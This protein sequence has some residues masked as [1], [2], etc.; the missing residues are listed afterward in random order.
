MSLVRTT[1]MPAEPAAT[2]DGTLRVWNNDKDGVEAG[3]PIP[4]A[5]MA[6][7]AF[8][9]GGRALTGHSDGSV[10]LWDLENGAELWRFTHTGAGVDKPVP[11][12]CG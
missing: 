3:K 5:K 4:A 6:C 11:C 8:W 9:P 12:G 1:G 10:V 2:A 7:T